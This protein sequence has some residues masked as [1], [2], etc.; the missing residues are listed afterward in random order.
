MSRESVTKIRKRPVERKL[1]DSEEETST[2]GKK[3]LR[4]CP[5]QA[6]PPPSTTTLSEA[7]PLVLTTALFKSNDLVTTSHSRAHSFSQQPQRIAQMTVANQPS[8]QNG[9][10]YPLKGN[11]TS[12][13]A[14]GNFL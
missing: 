6:P 10:L 12:S 14:K 1:E 4:V 2:T 8:E 9:S 11:P 5:T 3:K 7:S 13:T